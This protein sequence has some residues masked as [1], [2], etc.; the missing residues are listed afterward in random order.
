MSRKF[1]NYH[2]IFYLIIAILF[3]FPQFAFA[4]PRLSVRAFE[5]RSQEKDAPAGAVMDMMVTELDKAGIFDLIERERFDV[6]TQEMKLAQSGMLDPDTI[7]EIGKIVSAQYSMMG[8]IALYYYNE[9]ANGF[10]LPIIGS[11]AQKKT[12]YVVL[13]IRI[14]DNYTGRIVYTAEEIGTANRE[15]KGNLATY[16]GFFIGGYKK[17]YGG[18]LGSATRNAILKHVAAI[19]KRNW[20]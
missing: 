3:S 2:S 17:T 6:I 19:K 16:K 12:A 9:K 15:A 5:D 7:P 18:I 4:K 8:A 20:D 11:V 1:L 14:I 13:E 10:L